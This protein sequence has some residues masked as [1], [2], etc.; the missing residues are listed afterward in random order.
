MGTDA[1]VIVGIGSEDPVQMGLAQDQDMVQAFSP[2]RAD[3]AFYVSVLR[4][5]AGRG[6][7]VA[8]AHRPDP[9]PDDDTA[10]AVSIADEVAG[11]LV[12]RKGLGD[13]AS[14]PFGGWVGGGAGPHQTAS[15][16]TDDRQAI[17]NANS[18]AKIL[19]HGPFGQKFT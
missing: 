11:R 15:P 14:N 12:P 19:E 10:G 18:A 16:E 4:R 13:L 9:L 3:E 6:W 8:D 7:S 2:D 1:I 5:R 17:E